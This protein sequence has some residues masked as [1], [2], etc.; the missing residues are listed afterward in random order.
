MPYALPPAAPP[1]K[2]YMCPIDP[3]L[4]LSQRK[5]YVKDPRNVSK[6]STIN[7]GFLYISG[8]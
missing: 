3:S 4:P 7:P 1:I 5:L 6:H 8:R 2:N